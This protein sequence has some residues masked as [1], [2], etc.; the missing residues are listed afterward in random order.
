MSSNTPE[1][2][3]FACKQSE[4]LAEDIAKAFGITLGNVITSHYS[5]GEFQPSFEESVR[6]SRVFIIGSTFPNS[7]HLMEMLLMLDAAK[8]SS[9]RHIT[10]VLPYFGWARQDR[11]DKP[12]VPIAAKLVAKMLE[13]AGATRIITM[14]LHADQ[15][16]G[17]FEK[18]VDHLFASTIFLPY[19]RKLNLANLTIASPDMGG[20]KRA[21][22]YSKAMES[23]VVICYKQ[24]AKANVISYME[25]IGDVEGKNV[26]LVDDMVDTAGTL[27]KAADLMIERGAISVRAICTHPILSGNAYERLEKS[28]LQELIVTDSIPLRKQSDKIRVLTCANLFADVMLSVNANK[29]I[30]SKF[31]M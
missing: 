31:L 13:T 30:S 2:K 8:R 10:A 1:P 14:D 17:F 7:D 5:D 15:I 23:D 11:K 3:I 28:K 26:V 16:Q 4:A 22:A 25:L 20:S 6:G 27:T 18:P 29:S 21:Y 9:A 19:L 24:R 12:R